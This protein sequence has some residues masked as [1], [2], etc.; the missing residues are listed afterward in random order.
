MQK[1]FI[2]I[3]ALSCLLTLG[4]RSSCLSGSLNETEESGGVIQ[5]PDDGDRDNEDYTLVWSDEFEYEGLPESTKWSYD[6]GD[7]C[8][9][10]CGWGNNE[11]QYYTENRQA[12][13]RVENGRL[14]IEVRNEPYK[15]REY[16]SAR[17]LTRGKQAWRYGRIEV[18]ARLPEGKGTWPAIWMLPEEWA[19]GGWPSS[20]EIDIMEHVG[21][22]PFRI[23]GSVHT[24]A[25][26]HTDGTQFTEMLKVP[27]AEE[28]FHRYAIE[29]NRSEIR[30]YVD[31]QHY[32]TFTNKFSSYKEWPFDRAF[33]LILN[34]AVGGNWG[35]AE[36]IDDSIWPQKMEVEYVRVYQKE[37]S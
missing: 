33:H 14:I 30:W 21:F 9:D 36:G 6:V 25:Y 34:I 8:P 20:G 22:E 35:G 17:L 29:W 13:A 2:N 11:R 28:T 27:D 26:N 16:T 24:E 15:T 4:H 1:I 19:Y 10:L 32:A 37:S 31:D 23:Y 7:G 5:Q 18:E 12:N 3:L